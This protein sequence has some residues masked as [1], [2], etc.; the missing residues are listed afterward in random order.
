MLA[1]SQALVQVQSPLV[2]VHNLEVKRAD[3][4]FDGAIL[5]KGHGFTAPAASAILFAQ[6]ELVNE[7]IA[8]QPLQAITEAK[9]DVAYESF[10]VE[11]EPGAALV[12]IP[13]EPCQSGTGFLAIIAVSVEGVV[14]L[15]EIEEEIR[16]R[17]M[18]GAKV[19]IG[20]HCH[21]IL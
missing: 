12:G 16:V 4:E 18:G 17:Y 10:A 7:G 20:V 6:V 15:H 13:Q 2:A 1:K 14:R 9:H 11:D 5:E 3:T 8:P 19:G 21:S